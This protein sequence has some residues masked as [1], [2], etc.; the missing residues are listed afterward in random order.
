MKLRAKVVAYSSV[1]GQSVMLTD[2]TGRVVAILA[3]RIPSP[4]YPYPETAKEVARI[5]TEKI[6]S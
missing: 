2:E 5:I 1:V 6:N 4:S 3:V